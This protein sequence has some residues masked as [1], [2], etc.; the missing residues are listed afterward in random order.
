MNDKY[1][2]RYC[3]VC[4][5]AIPVHIRNIEKGY[6]ESPSRYARHRYCSNECKYKGNADEQRV[7]NPRVKDKLYHV[8]MGMKERCN[9][10][11][12]INAKWYFEKGI[13]VCQE[14]EHDFDAFKSWS[15]SNG[16]DYL[17]NRKEQSLD[18]I[19]GNKGYSPDNCRWVTHSVNCKNTSRNVFI[20]YQG[21]KQCVSDWSKETG[22]PAKCLF[23]R[24]K[25][26]TDVNIIFD[27]RTNAHRSNTG[28]KGITWQ[29]KNQ[30]YVIYADGHKY[31]GVRRSL[32]EAIELR[33]S[34]E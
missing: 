16:Y 15:L 18:R 33:R 17:K 8:W 34:S 9:N 31:L 1:P 5:K 10:H 23:A 30:R 3:E 6:K 19:D 7:E 14:W 12:N 26:T 22:I 32:D 20:E 4:G 13:K 27:K 25:K 28:I 21:K 2:T 24:C 29:E 11:N